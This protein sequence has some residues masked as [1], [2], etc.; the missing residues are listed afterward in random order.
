MRRIALAFALVAASC[1]T[2]TTTTTSTN[3]NQQHECVNGACTCKAGPKSGQS[4][5]NPA[6]GT[7]GSSDCTTFCRYCS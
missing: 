2:T 6:S 5:C 1:G 7:C 3:C 4:C